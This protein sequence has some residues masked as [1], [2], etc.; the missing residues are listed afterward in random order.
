MSDDAQLMT[1]F[2]KSPEQEE[3]I[4]IRKSILRFKGDNEASMNYL[5]NV[6]EIESKGESLGRPSRELII[7][8]LDKYGLD[9]RKAQQAIREEYHKRR[10]EELKAEYAK[11][12]AEA[13]KKKGA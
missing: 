3:I 4:Y 1:L 13:D 6:A 8:E 5:K 11:K 7:A 9:K 2:G 10:D 12:K